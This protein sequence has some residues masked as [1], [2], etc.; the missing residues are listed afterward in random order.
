MSDTRIQVFQ[1]GVK[2]YP[3]AHGGVESLV[4]N[5]I[6]A[7]MN[8]YDFTV[9]TVW[10]NAVADTDKEENV[11]VYQLKKGWFS[12]FWQ[13]RGAVT[14]KKNT[15]LQFHMEAFIPLAIVFSLLGF[16][17]VSVIHGRSWRNVKIHWFIRCMIAIV[18]VLGVNLVRRTVY[19]SKVDFE[20]MRKYTFRRDFCW[21][22]NASPICSVINEHP[23]KDMVFIGRISI[24]K[25]LEALI[26]AAE[27]EKRELDI[28]G[29]FD[30]REVAHSA[31]IRELLAKAKYVHYRGVLST[32]QVYPAISQYRCMVNPSKSEASPNAVIEAGACGLFLYLSDIP[33]HR[34]LGYPDVY[35]FDKDDIRLPMVKGSEH[36]SYGNIHHHRSTLSESRLIDQYGKLYKS[37]TDLNDER[38]ARGSFL[39]RAC[40]VAFLLPAW[41]SPHTRL[42]V[43]FHRVRGVRIGKRCEIGYFVIM[44]NVHPEMIVIEDEAVVTAR[45]TLLEHDNSKYYTGRGAVVSS[46]VTVKRGAFVGIGSVIFP[47]VSIGERAIVGALSFVKH[48]VPA[49]AI[50]CGQPAKE[51]HKSAVRL[52][53]EKGGA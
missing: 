43:F 14:N 52:R 12:R 33:G 30:E 39:R 49:D 37:L 29:P 28:F 9:F 3:A 7:A 34:G 17:V 24:Q 45:C 40:G 21:I 38:K 18:D 36:R 19:V 35:Y 16:N 50:V 2:N 51:I 10:A 48:N 4:H 5:F 26:K 1:I 32:E 31:K 13:I 6:R 46:P 11:R 15:I 8:L 47:G 42:R 41:F 44:G 23:T 53:N 25:N 20:A 27:K 22:P